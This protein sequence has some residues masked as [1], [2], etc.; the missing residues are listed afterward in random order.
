MASFHKILKTTKVFLGF[1][2][3]RFVLHKLDCALILYNKLLESLLIFC[4]VKCG[5][6]LLFRSNMIII[7]QSALKNII[8]KLL[9]WFLVTTIIIF[10]LVL[11]CFL[12]SNCVSS[13]NADGGVHEAF[14][15]LIRHLINDSYKASGMKHQAVSLSSVNSSKNK[16][17]NYQTQD[18]F[19]PLQVVVDLQYKV[20]FFFIYFCSLKYDLVIRNNLNPPGNWD[21]WSWWNSSTM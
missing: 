21:H 15:S 6:N 17:Q 7:R 2:W 12:L 9:N 18:F 5:N 3:F 8:I 19:E 1:C 14:Q 13:R 11:L 16:S 10:K 20:V 4:A